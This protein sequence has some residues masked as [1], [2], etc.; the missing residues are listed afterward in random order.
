MPPSPKRRRR[1]VAPVRLR[2]AAIQHLDQS[3]TH[4]YDFGPQVRHGRRPSIGLALAI[5]GVEGPRAKEIS[6]ERRQPAMKVLIAD[7]H[8]LVLNGVR[9]ALEG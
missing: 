2:S 1:P 6:R 7:D 8:Q 3:V 9:S 4:L 5:R